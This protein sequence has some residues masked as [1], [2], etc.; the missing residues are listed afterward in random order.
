MNVVNCE[1]RT[2]FNIGRT[3]L[4]GGAAS[5]WE[6]LPTKRYSGTHGA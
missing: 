4:V 1:S 5:F 2:V 6:V 3:A